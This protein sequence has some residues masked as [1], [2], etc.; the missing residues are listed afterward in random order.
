MG[1]SGEI[2]ELLAGGLDSDWMISVSPRVA[3]FSFGEE[4]L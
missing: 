1:D 4:N 3:C 2:V